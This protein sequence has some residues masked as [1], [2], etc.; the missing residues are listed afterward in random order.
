MAARKK[1]AVN[2]ETKETPEVSTEVLAAP[3][4]TE[5]RKEIPEVT[6][7]R[8]KPPKT[9]SPENT[10]E[11]GGRLIEIKP[12]KVRYQRDRTASFYRI[13]EM[14]PLV[15][16]LGM[17]RNSFGDGRDGDKAVS[18]WLI[19]VTDD[20]ELITEHYDELDTSMIEK[21]LAIVRRVNKIDEKEEK[22]KNALAPGAKEKG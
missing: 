15:D 20:P 9:G 3:E 12:T 18:D 7:E 19:A 2:T 11:I 4:V 8:K 5:E 13:L 22:L 10:L 17:E 14:Y 6:K 21:L 1:P 16:V